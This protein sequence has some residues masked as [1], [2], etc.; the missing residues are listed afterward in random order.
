M[1]SNT[2]YYIDLAPAAWEEEDVRFACGHVVR[3]RVQPTVPDEQWSGEK[4]AMREKRCYQCRNILPPIIAFGPNPEAG[5]N[6]VPVGRVG[7]TEA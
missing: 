7:K 6:V 4:A 5:K 2:A 3:F 1:L